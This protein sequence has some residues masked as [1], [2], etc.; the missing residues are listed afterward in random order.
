ML[1]LCC[2]AASAEPSGEAP[3]GKTLGFVIK[4]FQE[5]MHESPDN[6]P[7]GNAPAPKPDVVDVE[8]YLQSIPPADA[9][10]LRAFPRELHN[11]IGRRGPNHADVCEH[12]TSVPDPGMPTVAGKIAEGFDLDGTGDGHATANTCAHQKF[13]SPAGEAAIDNQLFRARGCINSA[14]NDRGARDNFMR[15]VFTMVLE[16]TGVDN[17]QNDPDVQVGFYVA[18][19]RM[20]KDVTG[21][22]I[23]PD[24]TFQIDPNPKYQTVVHGRIVNG[25]LT[26]DPADIPYPNEYI[27]QPVNTLYRNA[28]LRLEISPDGN[29][30]GLLGAYLDWR[31]IFA[32][33]T[34][35]EAL[36]KFSCDGYY[37]AL[38]RMADGY[39]DPKTGQCTAISAAYKIEAVRAFLYRDVKSASAAH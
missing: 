37:Y 36:S 27:I 35:T 21:A 12:P 38:Q 14:Y 9:A 33:T 15:N 19:D 28:R 16:V 5:A 30:K 13:T 1:G 8:Q 10:R 22:D 26:T 17:L 7:Q 25:V 6:C 4:S 24:A 18:L 39:P 34:R 32:P 23:L 3:K 20:Q 31:N 2:L 11:L 29:A